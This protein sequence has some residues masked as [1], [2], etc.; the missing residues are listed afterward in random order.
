MRV[1]STPWFR[2]LFV[3]PPLVPLLLVASCLDGFWSVGNIR[4][5]L[6]SIAVDGMVVAGLT[7]VMIAA[8][9]D[10]SLGAVMAMGGIAAIV[11][12]PYGLGV[13]LV[14]A[15]GLGAAAGFVSGALVT[16]LRINPF[17]ATLAVMV[18]V[19]GAILAFTGTRPVVGLEDHFLALGGGRPMPYAF[20]LMVGLLVV[21]HIG[22]TTRPWGRHV[23]A[24]GVD[25]RAAAMAGLRTARLK[26]ATY[27]LS[28]A[29]AGLAGMFL[30]ARLGTGSPIIGET[31]ALTAA[32][33]ALIGGATLKGGEGSIIGAFCGL[34]FVGALINVMNLLNIPSY[35]QHMTIGGLLILLVV[36]DGIV[37]R[38][39]PLKSET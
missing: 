2:M 13:S 27:V 24:V 32:A 37:D 38:L 29:L 18:I 17:I 33:A 36:G 11:L 22:L 9:F 21:L 12:L 28:G 26:S 39:T 25:E 35:F 31:T 30:A 4:I 1:V 14:G 10:L 34:L 23:Y 15:V 19:R 3:K 20:I 6:E 16:R 7:V 5:L 8:G